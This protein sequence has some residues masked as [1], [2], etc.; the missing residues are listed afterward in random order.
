MKINWKVRFKNVNFWIGLLGV[1]IAPI[2]SYYGSSVS[3]FTS[4]ESIADVIVQFVKNPYLIGSV[5]MAVLG[6]LGVITD[7]T[8]TGISD[9]KQ[10]LNYDK[11]KIDKEQ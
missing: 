2:L 11:P 3:D 1:A 5:V 8:T 4:W 9:S 7:H 6:W 10:A